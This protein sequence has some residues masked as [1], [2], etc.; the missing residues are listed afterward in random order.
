MEA[1][2]DLPCEVNHEKL[3]GEVHAAAPKILVWEAALD[4][5]QQCPCMSQRNGWCGNR[6]ATYNYDA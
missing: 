6:T 2:G 5:Y 4:S 3:P 1:L